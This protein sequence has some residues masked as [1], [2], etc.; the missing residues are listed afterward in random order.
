MAMRSTIRRVTNGGLVVG[1]AYLCYLM[2]LITAQ[3]LPLG[4]DVAFL[5]L[6]GSA[7]AFPYYRHAFFA[8]VFASMVVMLIGVGQFSDSFR[9]NWPQLHRGFGKGYIGLVLL[10]AAPTG[11]VLALHANGGWVAQASFVLQALLW[12]GFTWRAYAT[13]RRG[14][15]TAHRRYMWRSYAL[16]L[17][18]ISLRLFK[19]GIVWAFAPPPMDTYRIVAWL[20]WMVNLG[21]V[22]WWLRSSTSS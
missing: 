19:W 14:D 4:L 15:V 7:L 22:E 9:Q 11:L 10:V 6:K 5:R 3:Y 2:L 8:H 18:A 17:S 13:I 12:F 16:T 21:V 20:G 1:F